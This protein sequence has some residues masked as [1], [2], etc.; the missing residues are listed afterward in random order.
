MIQ[1]MLHVF[2]EGSPVEQSIGEH[3]FLYT[4]RGEQH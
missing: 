2:E 1:T 3:R 4:F